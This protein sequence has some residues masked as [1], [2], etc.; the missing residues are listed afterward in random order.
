[1]RNLIVW[2]N[3]TANDIVSG[4]PSDE[5]SLS[6]SDPANI[7]DF[8]GMLSESMV[9]VDTILLGRTTYEIF[10]TQWPLVA[11][12]PDVSDVVLRLGE[13]INT[14]RKVVVSGHPIEGLHWGAFEPPTQL[15]GTD[16][17]QQIRQWK[18]GD[19]GDIITFGSLTLV[20]SLTQAGLVD[21]YAKTIYP[22]VVNEGR[23]L[24]ENLDT[25]LDLR[26][27]SAET[28]EHDGIL[29]KYAPTDPR[30]ARRDPMG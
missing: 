16:A 7:E 27:I 23:R 8:S 20:Q 24:F 28:T 18:A 25:R 12:W 11:E 26:L 1:M 30:P 21:E 13:Q 2:I 9:G 22:V 10:T 3:S 15:N 19:G 17:E 14:A 5:K 4:P 29:V 6:W